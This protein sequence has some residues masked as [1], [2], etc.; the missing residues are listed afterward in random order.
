MT[1]KIDIGA[2]V[3]LTAE[4]RHLAILNYQ[5][6]PALLNPLVPAG[7]E[8]DLWE[9][10]AWASVVGFRFLKTRV[11]GLPVPFHNDFEEVNLRF[12]VRRVE[13]GELRRGVVFI[14]ELV[15]RWAVAQVA[16]MFYNERYRALP[17][18]HRLLPPDGE[19][20][21]E[22]EWRDGI[23]NRLRLQGHG[24]WSVPEPASFAAFIVEHYW[25]YS[26]QRDGSTLEYRVSHPRW[27]VR[28][29]TGSLAGAL[30]P[31][32]GPGW[33]GLLHAGPSS[34]L[35]AE[36]SPVAVSRGRRL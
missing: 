2:A 7:T 36:G 19:S 18:R 33:P 34:A 8:L 27:K 4:W 26:A 29:A 22:Y 32:G 12:Y 11:F 1:D 13:G 20:G 31:E 28:Q 25:G 17:M 16:R 30:A 15:P 14:Q 21:I 35:L 3:F 10:R 5:V 23:W 6:E 9:G 24:A